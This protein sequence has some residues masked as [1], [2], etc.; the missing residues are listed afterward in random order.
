MVTLDSTLARPGSAARQYEP[1][2]S[3][4]GMLLPVL[5]R[6]L[7]PAYRAVAPAAGS[8]LGLGLLVVAAF[9]WSVIAGLAAA[10]V[11]VLILE[12]RIKG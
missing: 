11:A 3:V 5:L 12:W 4:V 1:S 2:R 10:G 6:L 7:I 8:I 9:A